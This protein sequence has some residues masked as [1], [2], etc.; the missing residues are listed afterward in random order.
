M[1]VELRWDDPGRQADCIRVNSGFRQL[2]RNAT[3]RNIME[4]FRIHHSDQIPVENIDNRL[5]PKHANPKCEDQ[6]DAVSI[7]VVS[8]S[9]CGWIRVARRKE[10]INGIVVKPSDKPMDFQIRRFAQSNLVSR[11]LWVIEVTRRSKH[12]VMR[13][14][15]GIGRKPSLRTQVDHD[16]RAW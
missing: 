10:A 1:L 15:A 14:L 7:P 11:S 6:R 3:I 9:R 13:F 5:R 8:S 4:N 16:L 12:A 2:G